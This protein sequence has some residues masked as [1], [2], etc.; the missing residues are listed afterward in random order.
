[1]KKTLHSSLIAILAFSLITA[2][3]SSETN[4]PILNQSADISS[5]KNEVSNQY[6]V[7]AQAIIDKMPKVTNVADQ[8]K[9]V[10]EFIPLIKSLNRYALENLTKYAVKVLQDNI[11]PGENF[12]ETAVAKLIH[13][14]LQRQLDITEKSSWAQMDLLAIGLEED[15]AKQ[16]KLITAFETTIKKLVKA[17]IKDLINSLKG[18]NSNLNDFIPIGSPLSNRMLKIL[19]TRL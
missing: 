18:V 6:I 1:M 12:N 19:Q 5:N 16:E 2:C 11:K 7:T 10:K 13:P 17:D 14:I 9:L 4:L 8:E 3:S 15:S